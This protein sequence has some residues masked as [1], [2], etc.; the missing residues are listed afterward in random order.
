[1]HWVSALSDGSYCN[2][3]M[4]TRRLAQLVR[5]D[6][7]GGLYE[8]RTSRTIQVSLAEWVPCCKQRKQTPHL[9]S[10]Q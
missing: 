10:Q 1:M 9:F 3:K 7:N 8:D 5:A 4:N 2:L 6:L